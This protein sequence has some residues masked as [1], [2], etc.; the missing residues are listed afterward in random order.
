MSNHTG[1]PTHGRSARHGGKTIPDGTYNA[2]AKM[3]RRCLDLK[4]D[5]F[6]YYGGRGITFCPQ[7]GDFESFLADMGERPAGM[8]LDRVDVD[9][10]YSPA[11]CRWA[12]KQQQM[13]NKRDNRRFDWNGEDLCLAEIC[14]RT[15]TRYQLAWKR[16]RRG[17]PI[18]R[19]AA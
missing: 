17:W 15:G 1:N 11:N 4:S 18:E 9:G 5:K 6:R 10:P 8:T 13:R 12:T 14:E 7:W 3:R 19:A 16:L 2:W